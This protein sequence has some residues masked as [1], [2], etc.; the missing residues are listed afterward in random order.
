MIDFQKT[1]HM[2]SIDCSKLKPQSAKKVYWRCDN[3]GIE[4]LKQYRDC[5]K[6]TGLCLK[7][8]G[9]QQATIMGN[10]FGKKQQKQ[11]KCL[12]CS[13]PINSNLITCTEHRKQHLSNIKSGKNN[14]AWTGASQCACG[15][16]KSS[17]A[18]SCRECSFASGRRS[19]KNNGRW[20]EDRGMIVSARI[21]RTMLNNTMKSLGKK[22]NAKTPKIIGYSFKELKE[23]IESK[24][25]PWMNWNN[26]GSAPDQWSI[27]HII[28]VSV[29]IKNG[30][31]DPAIIN[32][33]WN[34]RPIRTSHNI[35]KSNSIDLLA[36]TLALEKLR[37]CI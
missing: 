18:V 11:G 30:I 19:G 24:F 9:K 35:K 7:C 14:P 34:L 13:L 33:L 25:E 8:N 3:C 36:K 26:Y 1:L 6:S 17:K 28:P 16:R 23:Y 21:A 5:I 27:D 20:I 37:L 12:Y 22:K 10:K 31:K 29:L 15:K 32:A 4:K 2:L